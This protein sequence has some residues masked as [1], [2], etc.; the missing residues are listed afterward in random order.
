MGSIERIHKDKD[1]IRIHYIAEWAKH[2]GVIQADVVRALDV[3]KGLVS[4]WFNGAVPEPKNLLRLAEMFGLDEA[5]SLF[6]HPDDDWIARFL[7]GRKR[8]EIDRAKQML[9][10]AFPPRQ[11]AG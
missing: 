1:A 8:D 9:E 3:D 7:R 11:K 10:L 5:G 4:K 2:R 6:R